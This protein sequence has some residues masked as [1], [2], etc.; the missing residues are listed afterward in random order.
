MSVYA[1]HPGWVRTEFFHNYPWYQKLVI[2]PVTW[3]VGKDPWH[4]SQTTLYCAVDESIEMD[5]GKYYW[6]VSLP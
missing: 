6:L 5:T 2:A 1:L 3:L 4:G